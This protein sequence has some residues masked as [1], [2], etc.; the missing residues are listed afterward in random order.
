MIF[1]VNVKRNVLEFGPKSI[2]LPGPQ[3]SEPIIPVVCIHAEKEL[4]SSGRNVR[5]GLIGG[6]FSSL[7]VDVR[8][9]G[10]SQ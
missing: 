4:D 2:C 3:Q 6:A 1:I 8:K 7:Q 10:G 9:S 5:I